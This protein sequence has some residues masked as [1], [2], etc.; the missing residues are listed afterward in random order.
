M[1]TG[2]PR[3]QRI[4]VPGILATYTLGPTADET[5]L[6]AR[7]TASLSAT[8]RPVASRGSPYGV[9]GVPYGEGVGSLLGGGAGEAGDEGAY[10][11]M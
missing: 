6:D 10:G 1:L 4:I 7:G 11:L 2:A 3:A 8:P 9:C 5:S